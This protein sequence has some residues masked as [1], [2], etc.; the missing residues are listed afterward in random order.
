MAERAADGAAVA[1]LAVP[2][3]QQRLVDDRPARPHHVGEFEVALA[4]HAADFERAA[5]FADV[6]QAFDAV[7]IDDVIGLHEPEIQ[8][9]H[10]RLPAR[11]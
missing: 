1:G 6:R 7:E 10:Q 5:G 3:L 4:R 9:R 11:Q 8:H 2:D